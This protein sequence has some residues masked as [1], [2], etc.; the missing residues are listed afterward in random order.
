MSSPSA[1]RADR[2]LV[3]R[4]ESALAAEAAAHARAALELNP[5]GEAEALE[6]GHARAVYSGQWSPVHGVFALGLEGEVTERDLAEIDR[7]Y[8]RKER[9]VAYWI[10][11]ETDPSLLALLERDFAPTRKV[12]MHGTPLAGWEPG[13]TTGVSAGVDHRQWSLA[14]T[15]TLDPAAREPGLLALTKL[16]QKETRFYMEANASYTYFRGGLALVTVPT[17]LLALQ[18]KEARDYACDFIA[19]AGV[20]GLPFLYERTLYERI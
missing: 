9:P 2:D 17:S 18:A 16:H 7:F 13:A 20:S 3:L 12:P 19:I 15:Q 14:F 10:T 5:F 6:L 11:P 4:I 1:A 8:F